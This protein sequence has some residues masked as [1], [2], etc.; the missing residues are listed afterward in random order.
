MKKILMILMVFII[1]FAFVAWNP[2]SG[3][4]IDGAN[5]V[6]IT[7]MTSIDDGTATLESGSLTG[8]TS[9]STEIVYAN[10]F[11]YGTVGGTANAITL[12]Y[13]ID[14]DAL[15]AGL[16]VTFIADSANTG[17]TTLTVDALTTKN[18]YEA[19]DKSA[20]DANDIKAGM[21]VMCMYDGTQWQQISQSGN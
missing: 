6:T 9:I 17:A 16:I 13:T 4:E 8:L 19:H 10:V 3:Y 18:L 12:D 21:I 2:Y 7:N 1:S 11:N 15:G 5:G 14:F 20:L